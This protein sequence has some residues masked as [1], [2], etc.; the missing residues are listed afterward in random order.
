MMGPRTNRITFAAATGLVLAISGCTGSSR[1]SALH[2]IKEE[3]SGIK[4]GV[5]LSDPADSARWKDVD[6]RLLTDALRAQGLQPDVQ[7]CAGEA[8][9]FAAMTDKMIS[10]GVKVLIDAAPNNEVGSIV[11]RKAM[12][13]HI[14]TIDYDYDGLNIGGSSDYAVSFDP[15]R[16]G[17]LQGRGL[18]LGVRSARV[19]GTSV[20]EITGPQ[21]DPLESLRAQAARNVLQPRYDSGAYRLA[22]SRSIDDDHRVGAVF[23]Q[24]L[25][26]NGGH[27]D[28]VLAAND[29]VAD[30]V[31]AVLRNKGLN[32]KVRVTGMGAT[33]QAL[34]AILRGDQF[35]TVFTPVDQQI[36][37]TAKLAS[38]LA[39][40][41][42]AAADNM[43]SMTLTEPATQHK[44]R[45]ILVPPVL[46][47]LRTI[48]QVIDSHLV[49]PSDICDSELA[50]RCDQLDIPR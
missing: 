8:T 45:A 15:I 18:A 20:I 43:V 35:M 40:N 16:A 47:T 21:T 2:K 22:A 27:V 3:A 30:A 5:V 44:I 25:N 41:D 17:D 26:A 48:K 46:I 23:E 36:T 32:G 12:A 33:P 37:A 28:D 34:K 49:A 19:H 29:G 10:N 4:V 50:L 13:R 38:A 31:I 9:M 1:Y 24:L 42:H 39:R 7:N 11:A 6:Q 14:A